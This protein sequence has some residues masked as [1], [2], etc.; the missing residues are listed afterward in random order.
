MKHTYIFSSKEIKKGKIRTK[1][2]I[3]SCSDC[4]FRDKDS[5]NVSTCIIIPK[6][7]INF[8]TRPEDCP[9]TEVEPNATFP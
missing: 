1:T 4:G 9:L 5:Q 2:P 8:D 7:E 3:N 6:V